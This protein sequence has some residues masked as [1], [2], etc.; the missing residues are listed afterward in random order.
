MKT[1]ATPSEIKYLA[2]LVLLRYAAGTG[3]LQ[4]VIIMTFAPSRLV[5]NGAAQRAKGSL[6]ASGGVIPVEEWGE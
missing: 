5:V 4:G 6:F 3:E 1:W 2:R